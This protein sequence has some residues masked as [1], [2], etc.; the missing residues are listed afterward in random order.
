MFEDRVDSS[1]TLMAETLIEMA[2]ISENHRLHVSN[3]RY[4]KEQAEKKVKE[5][6]LANQEA[7]NQVAT[8]N[9]IVNSREERDV[10]NA[11]YNEAMEQALCDLIRAT[12]PDK[13]AIVKLRKVL[14]PVYN[15]FGQCGSTSPILD[16]IADAAT[17]HK[18]K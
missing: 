12:K 16:A 5:L 4:G 15:F 3:E 13:K 9:R 14:E 7:K 6:T 2:K 11:R 10:E 18:K 1:P 17:K 8:L